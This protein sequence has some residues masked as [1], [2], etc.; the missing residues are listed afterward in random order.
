LKSEL[1]GDAI[2]VTWPVIVPTTAWSKAALDRVDGVREIVLD[3]RALR[4]RADDG[5]ERCPRCF[6]RSRP[7]ASRWRSVRVARPS[8]DDVYLR[9]AAATFDAAD[10]EAAEVTR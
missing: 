7:T 2:Y 8:L 1:R 6:K 10:A 3:G 4:A 9:Y 5:G